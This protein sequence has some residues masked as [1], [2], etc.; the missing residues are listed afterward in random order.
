[1]SS[2]RSLSFSLLAALGAAACASSPAPAA[3]QHTAQPPPPPMPSSMV[4]ADFQALV[5]HGLLAPLDLPALDHAEIS[6]VDSADEKNAAGTG[7][8]VLTNAMPG[9]WSEATFVD[10]QRRVWIVA[11]QNELH[12]PEG[13]SIS[14]TRVFRSHHELPP[15][16]V[17]G[18]RIEIV[19]RPQPARA[20]TPARA[21]I[22]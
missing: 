12:V 20:P 17:Y 18:G 15:G 7:V 3:L 8:L 21:P 5:D 19:A 16:H 13:V 9:G 6:F 22:G 2:L 14:A 10:N 11:Q 4:V 1:M